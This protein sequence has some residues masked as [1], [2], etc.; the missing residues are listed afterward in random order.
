MKYWLLCCCLASALPAADL[1]PVPGPRTEPFRLDP[2]FEEG[3]GISIASSRT[4]SFSIA[5]GGLRLGTIGATINF[6]GAASNVPIRWGDRLPGNIR[7]YPSNRIKPRY[8][9]LTQSS[10]YPGIDMEFLF[11][12]RSQLIWRLKCQP[13]CDWSQ[14]RVQAPQAVTISLNGPALLFRFGSGRLDPSVF[15][16]SISG[17]TFRPEGTNTFGIDVPGSSTVDIVLA[18]SS[19]LLTPGQIY[20]KDASG[21]EYVGFQPY[22]DLGAPPPYP[23]QRYRGCVQGIGSPQPCTDIALAKFSK[24]GE[25]LYITQFEGARS[26]TWSTLTQSPDGRLLLGGNTNSSNF[27]VT[28]GAFQPRYGGPEP[29]NLLP[30]SNR[31]TGDLWLARLNPATGELTAATFLGGPEEEARAR[32]DIAPDGTIF[33]QPVLFEPPA[34]DSPV[35]SGAFLTG[36]Q[37]PCRQYW[38]ARLSPNLNELLYGTYLPA[39]TTAT[40]VHSDGTLYFTGSSGPGF[41]TTPGAYQTANAGGNDAFL[42]R[43]DPT[44]RRLLFGTY[45]GGADQDSVYRLALTPDGSA[46]LPVGELQSRVQRFVHISNDG[47]K[48]L[49][50]IV[51]GTDEFTLDRTGVLHAT[52]RTSLGAGSCGLR[53]L[54]YSPTGETLSNFAIPGSYSYS[55]TGLG[56]NGLPILQINDSYYQVDPDRPRTTFL[57]CAVSP[58]KSQF[59]DAIAPGMFL[60]LFGEQLGP[61]ATK[62]FINGWDAPVTYSSENQVNVLVPF[63]LAT[64]SPADIEVESAGRKSRLLRVNRVTATNMTLFQVVLNQDG[65]VNTLQNPAERGSIVILW[66]TGGGNTRPASQSGEIVPATGRPLDGRLRVSSPGFPEHEL[67]YAGFAPGAPAGLI[68]INVRLNPDLKNIPTSTPGRTTLNVEVT[69]NG[70]TTVDGV[71]LYYRD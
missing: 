15:F 57:G 34:G 64:G 16:Y 12:D 47:A 60:T 9:N 32:V 45:F 19:P 67:L 65:T 49:A 21:S 42:G 36:C 61:A 59:V 14:V 66:G 33:I 58:A 54:R 69:S 46:W 26:E 63:E 18:Q 4:S 35:T 2:Y 39:G 52:L 10:V 70:S 6:L 11:D 51:S 30:S 68:Q 43:L 71:T 13:G 31:P 27:P 62:V 8:R 40:A 56:D 50:R 41:P 38:A 25:L 28:P 55:F 20:F 17:G 29:A 48:V 53:Y 5:P 37:S 23:D 44:G 22:D 7:E 3:S 24:S 1:I